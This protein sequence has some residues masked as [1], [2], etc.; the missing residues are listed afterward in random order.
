MRM[1][2]LFFVAATATLFLCSCAKSLDSESETGVDA[3]ATVRVQAIASK[4]INPTLDAYGTVGFPPEF[5]HSLNAS[6]E[7]R[8]DRVLVSS[9]ESVHRGQ[10]MVVV[11]PTANTSLELSK[12]Q[13]DLQFGTQELARVTALRQQQLA[14][15]TELASARLAHDN[16]RAIMNN[17][18]ARLGNR[19]GEI[20]AN[21]DGFIATVDAQQGDIVPAGGALLH[22]ADHA[23][24]RL[25]LGIEPK[26]LTL[27]KENQ[28][29]SIFD[30]YD[31]KVAA[32]GRVIKLVHQIDPQTRLAEA[33][34]DVDADSGLLPGS[35]VKAIIALGST[36][37][38]L[39]VP[40][41]AVLYSEERA[42]VFIVKDGK[43][44]QIWIKAGED[45]DK[46]LEILSGLK[47]GD[48]V[49]VEGNY[50]LVD[51]MQVKIAA[52]I[53]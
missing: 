10:I 12:A 6:A 42:Y 14:T 51:G 17:V 18:E 5:L 7:V 22:I 52:A 35:T 39:M 31:A 28:S 40:R 32:K 26:D 20:Q 38:A 37:N 48:Q 41:S 2:G 1:K 15:N 11:Q 50:E 27:I 46:E 19:N 13:A 9:G 3:I 47:Q 45:G 44:V 49:I 23:N 43:A 8:V 29:V 34:V 21:R 33:L 24:L 4:T 16:M 25:R 30:I 53:K 36:T